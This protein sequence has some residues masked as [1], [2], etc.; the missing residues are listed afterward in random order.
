[1]EIGC[2]LLRKRGKLR[3]YTNAHLQY[4]F[5]RTHQKTLIHF[6]T[7]AIFLLKRRVI[8]AQSSLFFSDKCLLGKNGY[9]N[10]SSRME[11]LNWNLSVRLPIETIRQMLLKTSEMHLVWY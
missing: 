6:G 9:M 7:F 10:F 2:H 3:R 11:K 5:Y 8:T 4:F 1:M